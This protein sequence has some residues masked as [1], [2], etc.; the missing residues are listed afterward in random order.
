MTTAEYI[1]C[2]LLGCGQ[3]DIEPMFG[4]MTET[5]VFADA[6]EYVN[7]NDMSKDASSIWYAG[8]ENTLYDVFGDAEGFEPYF[9]Y[10]DSSVAFTGNPEEIEDFEVKCEEFAK[11]TGYDISY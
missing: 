2:E 11:L 5:G 8:I 6:M 9:N 7:S 4:T 3:L 10:L 1:V